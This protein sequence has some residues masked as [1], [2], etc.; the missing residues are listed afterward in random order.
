MDVFSKSPGQNIKP[1]TFP[2]IPNDLEDL[3]LVPTAPVEVK[4]SIAGPVFPSNFQMDAVCPPAVPG[5]VPF[6]KPVCCNI[7]STLTRRKKIIIIRRDCH[8][9][10]SFETSCGPEA[11]RCCTDLAVYTFQGEET[12]VGV[13]CVD[14]LR[15]PDWID[16]HPPSFQ[17]PETQ[18][19]THP[20]ACKNT[21]L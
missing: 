10:V 3:A 2:P 6:R 21:N 8:W 15:L 16:P 17:K 5:K 20:A 18:P 7:I 12:V 1:L 19:E 14:I 9:A 11:M 4:N 13:H